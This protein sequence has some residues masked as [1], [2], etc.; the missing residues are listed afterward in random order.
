MKTGS[1][2][3][4]VI[5]GIILGL[6]AVLLAWQ[7]NPGNMAICIACFIRDT[8]GAMKFHSAGI[9]QYMRPEIVGIVIGAFAVSMATKEYRSTAGSSPMIRFLLGVIMMIGSLVFLGCPLRMVLRMS[10]GDLNAYVALIGFVLGVF[11]GT[12][13]LK[14]GFSL[15]RAYPT[16]AS[17]GFV[18]PAVLA[19]LLILSVTTTLFVSSESGPGSL[20]APILISLAGGLIFGAIAQRSRACFAGG[21][22]DVILMKNFDLL[23]VIGCIFVVML[24]YNVATGN[25]HL[26]FTGQP[27]AHA[28]HLWNILGMYVVGFAAVLAGGCPLRQLVL[29]GQGSSDSA[30]TFLGLFVGAA[31]CHNFGLAAAAAAAAT[32]TTAAVAGGPAT[33]GKVAIILCIVVLFLIGFLPKFQKKEN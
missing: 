32:E 22:R 7:G 19:F 26:S 33:A 28:Q 6:V 16:K 17:S 8:A 10:A 13:A 25:F 31:I 3:K 15:G 2:T 23:S 4:K 27:V 14:R 18:L 11:T 20:H 29:A 21:F 12:L 1:L 9:V 24:I 30:V 5:F